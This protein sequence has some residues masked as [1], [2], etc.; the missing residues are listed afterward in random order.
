VTS[1]QMRAPQVPVP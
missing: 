1:M